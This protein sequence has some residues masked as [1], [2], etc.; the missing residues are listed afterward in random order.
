ML[1]SECA[2]DRQMGCRSKRDGLE[3]T[4]CSFLRYTHLIF[5]RS[6]SLMAPSIT[7]MYTTI[8]LVAS[9]VKFETDLDNSGHL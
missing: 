3:Y 4:L 9:C 2:S 7:C 8:V 5:L 6:Q 1:S